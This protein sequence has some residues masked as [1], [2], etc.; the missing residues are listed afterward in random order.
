M[1]QRTGMIKGRPLA[2]RAGS[3]PI[4]PWRSGLVERLVEVGV[5]EDGFGRGDASFLDEV[6]QGG[7]AAALA[8]GDGLHAAHAVLGLELGDGPDQDPL[9]LLVLAGGVVGLEDLEQ[10]GRRQGGVEGGSEFFHFPNMQSLRPT[11]RSKFGETHAWRLLRRKRK[12][13]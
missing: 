2:S 8:H 4:R 13:D 10:F 3:G 12:K 11:V 7:K 9:E 6:A 1:S 5:L